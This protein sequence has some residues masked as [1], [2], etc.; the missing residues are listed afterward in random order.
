M[1]KEQ[2]IK[3][4]TCHSKLNLE[5]DERYDSCNDCPYKDFENCS[6]YLTT[7]ALS[8]LASQPLSSQPILPNFIKVDNFILDANNI[9]IIQHNYLHNEIL[10]FFKGGSP[11]L[12][13]DIDDHNKCDNIFSYLVEQLLKGVT[14]NEKQNN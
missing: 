10:V 6:V 7:D 8:V 5:S 1:T 12:R 9:E 3:G 2:I 14:P 13:I 11:K 4:L